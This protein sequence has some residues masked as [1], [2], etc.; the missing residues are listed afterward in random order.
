MYI[1]EFLPLKLQS[2]IFT[3]YNQVCQKI[4]E[5]KYSYINM[6]VYIYIDQKRI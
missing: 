4:K 5:N 3:N 1:D 6:C 2:I